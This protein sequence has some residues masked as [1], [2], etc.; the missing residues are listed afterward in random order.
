MLPSIIYM[1]IQYIV[2]YMVQRCSIIYPERQ[3]L[4]TD[5][6]RIASYLKY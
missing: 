1:V 3:F 4:V 5:M 6:A 2:W